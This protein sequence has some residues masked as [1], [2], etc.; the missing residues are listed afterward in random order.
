MNVFL[1]SYAAL[2]LGD[3][4][5]I[6]IICERYPNHNFTIMTDAKYKKI[7]EGIKN[8]S[9]FPTFRG[10]NNIF[11]YYSR[12]EIELVKAADCTVNIGGSIFIE[13]ETEHQSIN[14]REEYRD[15]I[16]NSNNFFVIGSNF[17]PYHNDSFYLDYKEMFSN[18]N[19]ICFRERLSYDKFNDLSNVRLAPDVVFSLDNNNIPV[20]KHEKFIV[21]SVINLDDRNLLKEYTEMYEETIANLSNMLV[22]EGYNIVLMSF[23]RAE[24]DESA[25]TRIKSRIDNDKV[26]TY[27]Y[28]GN[29]DESLA[30]IK[31]SDGVVATRFHSLILAWVFGMPVVPLIYSN[32]TTNVINDVGYSK[33]NVPISQMSEFDYE[34]AVEELTSNNALDI[35][36]ITLESNQQFKALDEFLDL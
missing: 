21:I 35:N 25:I 36:H 32:K 23:C 9:V 17:G 1:K 24:G 15:L 10:I 13:P 6:K 19:D 4:L 8:L 31:S 3:D 29:L 34:L 14:K 11:G 27:F 20:L 26:M 5:F 22:D 33:Y 7:Y 18:V 30:L 16:T 12:K 28:R 2:N